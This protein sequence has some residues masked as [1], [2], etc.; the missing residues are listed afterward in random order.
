MSLF[1]FKKIYCLSHWLLW[2]SIMRPQVVLPIILQSLYIKVSLYVRLVRF[3]IFLATTLQVVPPNV[4]FTWSLAP[5]FQAGETGPSRKTPPLRQPLSPLKSVGMRAGYCVL[6]SE[7]STFRWTS[8]SK[9]SL[10]RLHSPC[11]IK[12]Q[13]GPKSL[14]TTKIIFTC[15]FSFS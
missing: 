7:S 2:T 15:A 11:A 6:G 8:D 14:E 13:P 5:A 12:P 4:F 3:T 10:D 1:F 9:P